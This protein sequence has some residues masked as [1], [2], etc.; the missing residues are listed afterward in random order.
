MRLDSI[1]KDNIIKPYTVITDTYY[2]KH[3]DQV[4]FNPEIKQF[5]ELIST[6]KYILDAGCGPGGESQKIRKL[7]FK[8]IGIDITPSMVELAQ[9]KVKDVNFEVM[10]VRKM[11]FADNTF[12]GIWTART[13][14]HIP[15]IEL[16]STFYEFKRV[17]KSDG[18]ICACVLGGDK[19][20]I[21][22]EYYDESG[23]TSTFFHYFSEEKIR[24]W[25]KIVGLKLIKCKTIY[26]GE[27]KEPHIFVF[28]RKS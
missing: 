9:E 8:V 15:S 21:E 5:L 27:D 23:S 1:I 25:I 22:P 12:D 28:A 17:L 2:Q 19:E 20:E 10:D 16:E 14:I 3:F 26:I 7:G 4:E 11:S 6:G 24:K 13:L 18:I